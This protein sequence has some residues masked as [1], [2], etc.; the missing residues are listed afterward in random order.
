[1]AS[2]D[3]ASLR[4]QFEDAKARIAALRAAGKVPAEAD[5]LFGLLISLVSILIALLLER[6]TRKTS[7]NSGLPPSQTEKDDTARR[8]GR[9]SGKG[10]RPNL[11][12]ADS[13]RRVTVED[14]AA[15]DTCGSCGAD[16]S[17]VEAAGQWH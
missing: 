1:M 10:A 4:G 8:G 5:A 14:T 3:G 16:L 15:V 7:A 12:T 13:M 9:D 2:V 6:T 17:G 11:K